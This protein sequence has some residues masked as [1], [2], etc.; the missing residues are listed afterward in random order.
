MNN[1]QRNVVAAGLVLAA[2]VGLFP[3]W[4]SRR[5]FAP[6]ASLVR[7]I[8]HSALFSPPHIDTITNGTTSVAVDT[9]R[10]VA[11]WAVLLLVT[12]AVAVLSGRHPKG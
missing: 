6:G 10:L 11:Y 3:P 4:E 5:P 12:G 8:G 2:L 9:Q 7:H 1:R